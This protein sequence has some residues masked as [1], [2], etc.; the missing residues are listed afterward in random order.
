M[1][2]YESTTRLERWA[3]PPTP[4]D[5][6]A[7]RVTVHVAGDDRRFELVPTTPLPAVDCAPLEVLMALEPVFTLRLDDSD[8]LL[9][10][11]AVA[12]HTSESPPSPDAEDDPTAPLAETLSASL[13]P[14]TTP[15]AP[16]MPDHAATR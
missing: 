12:P 2:T 5:G 3:N 14:C 13:A 1:D 10:D 16:A 4:L 11:V 9:V 15:A 7:M 6:V 8:T